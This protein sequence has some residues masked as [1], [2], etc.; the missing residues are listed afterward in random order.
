MTQTFVWDLDGTLI[1]SY[2]AIMRALEATYQ[3]YQLSFDYEQLQRYI[4]AHSVGQLLDE[5]AERKQL[6][7]QKLKQFYSADLKKRDAELQ[8]F[9][10]SL[11]ILDWTKEKGIVNFIYTHKGNNTDHVLQQLGIAAY[12]TESLHSQSGFARKP[13][14]EAMNY[15]VEKY[16]LEKNQT[17]YIGDRKLDMEFALNSG[18]QSINLT[19][20]NSSHNT[21]I[22]N[23]WQITAL[24]FFK[25]IG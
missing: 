13:S 24:P 9:P 20:E 12:F 17:Y 16:G 4:L 23:L 14:P 5:I 8:L 11:A 18:V 1:D 25:E 21:K 15:L 19:Q 7:V 6:D 10:D 2:P 3:A 22:D